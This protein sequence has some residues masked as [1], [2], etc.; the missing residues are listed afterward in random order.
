[1]WPFCS[2]AQEGSSTEEANSDR[3][4]G[5]EQ[6]FMGAGGRGSWAGGGERIP[7]LL[8]AEMLPHCTGGRVPKRQNTYLAPESK[9]WAIQACQAGGAGILLR[10]GPAGEAP[11]SLVTSP[12]S[13]SSLF[14]MLPSPHWPECSGDTPL[15]AGSQLLINLF[16][17]T[18]VPPQ[19][20][21]TRISGVDTERA[22]PILCANAATV[23]HDNRE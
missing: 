12:T 10:P 14:A 15:R 5:E 6:P 21:R 16:Q 18:Q 20:C 11:G 23:P 2:S 17:E 4:L 7:Q 13:G 1:M 19:I 3:V 8:Q 9:S 22:G